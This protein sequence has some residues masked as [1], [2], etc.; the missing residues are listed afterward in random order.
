MIRVPDTEISPELQAILASNPDVETFDSYTMFNING[1]MIRCAVV[2]FL[3][4][5]YREGAYLADSFSTGIP[6]KTTGSADDLSKPCPVSIACFSL[7]SIPLCKI[8]QSGPDTLL[9]R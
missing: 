9:L 5:R 6:I 8:Y 1:Q 4:C 7:S 3:K 2:T